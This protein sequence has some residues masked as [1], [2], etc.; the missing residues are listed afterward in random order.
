MRCLSNKAVN[1]NRRIT[2]N[3]TATPKTEL[4][5]TPLGILCL[6]PKKRVQSQSSC[7]FKHAGVCFGASAT[8]DRYVFVQARQNLT[9]TASE[10]I[11]SKLLF[12]QPIIGACPVYLNKCMSTVPEPC[13]PSLQLSTRA[14][15]EP[16]QKAM[17]T[18]AFLSARYER[19]RL[20]A[21][22]DQHTDLRDE[23][24]ILVGKVTVSISS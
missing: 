19:K 21:N 1:A 23:N 6:P 2:R 5:E 18:M 17:T 3:F 15:N 16:A 11:Q 8:A 9:T 7:L 14:T 4:E 24:V 13:P 12:A 20:V 10:L 22:P